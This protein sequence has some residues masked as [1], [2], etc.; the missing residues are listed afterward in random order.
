MHLRGAHMYTV[1]FTVVPPEMHHSCTEC[2]YHFNI[3]IITLTCLL[4]MSILLPSTTKGKFSG[5]LGLA[6]IKNS[7]RQLSSDLKEF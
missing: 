1:L 3:L 2:Y 7:S 5:S 4:S 6:W